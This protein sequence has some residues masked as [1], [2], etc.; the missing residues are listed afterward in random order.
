MPP[1]KGMLQA[2]SEQGFK[3]AQRGG[4]QWQ[5]PRMTDPERAARVGLA[6]A[7]APR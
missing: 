3:I 7:V 2:W 5:R 4:W 6:V 1:N